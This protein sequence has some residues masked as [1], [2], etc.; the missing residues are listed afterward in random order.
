MRDPH[1]LWWEEHWRYVAGTAAVVAL[2]LLVRSFGAG[3]WE[4]IGLVL[5]GIFTLWIGGATLLVLV[6]L[7]MYLAIDAAHAVRALYHWLDR[8]L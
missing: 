1:K 5:G 3:W 4:S 2:I 8:K 7:V 6:R